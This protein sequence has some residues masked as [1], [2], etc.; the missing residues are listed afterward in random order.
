MLLTICFH[1]RQED[2]VKVALQVQEL[3][4]QQEREKQQ[5]LEEAD[6][7]YARHLQD[8]EKERIQ[9]KRREK[10]LIK[11]RKEVRRALAQHSS[12]GKFSDER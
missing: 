11:E 10:G 9:K 8:K 7:Q 2:D 1:P 4:S 6:E 12:H 5:H 3:L